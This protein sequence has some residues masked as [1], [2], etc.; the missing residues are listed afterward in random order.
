[1]QTVK[2]PLN[3]REHRIP[4]WVRFI[5]MDATGRWLLFREKPRR[6]GRI[7]WSE[8]GHYGQVGSMNDARHTKELLKELLDWEQM[9]FTV[10]ELLCQPSKSQ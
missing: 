3:E 1:M 6:V 9:L 10:E 4:D 8:K 7:W 2:I 5:A